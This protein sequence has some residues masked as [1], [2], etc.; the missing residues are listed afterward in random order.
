MIVLDAMA[1]EACRI[2]QDKL[3]QHCEGGQMMRLH[4]DCS[5]YSAA[6]SV[7]LDQCIVPACSLP[8]ASS[9]GPPLALW[10]GGGRAPGGAGCWEAPAGGRSEGTA[11]GGR[12]R[13][14]EKAG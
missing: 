4:I 8:A 6:Q 3:H 5:E 9:A 13:P 10:R 2:I 11:P 12:T 7:C 14:V 1:L